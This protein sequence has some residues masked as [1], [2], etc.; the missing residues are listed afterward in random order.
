MGKIQLVEIH[1]FPVKGFSGQRLDA[2]QLE[3]GHGIAHDRRF[4]ITNGSAT[5][6]EWMPA[7]SFFINAVNDGMQKFDLQFPNEENVITLAGAGGMEIRIVPDDPKSLVEANRQIAEF[8]APVGLDDDRDPP[9]IVERAE[10]AGSGNSGFW[11]FTDT[12]ISVLNLNSLKSIEQRTG[13]EIDPRRFRANLVISGLPAWEEFGLLGTVLKVGDAELEVMRPA[14]RCPATSIDP[15]TGERDLTLPAD[16]QEHFG[17]AF[18]AMYARVVKGGSIKTGDAVSLEGASSM[19]LDE[20]FNERA[21]DY[22]LWPRIATIAEYQTGEQETKLSLES[23]SPWPL[24]DAKPGQRIRF[25]LDGPGWTFEEV[26]ATSPNRYQFK[27][28]DSK[29]DDPLTEMLRRGL[30]LGQKLIVSGPFGK[31]DDS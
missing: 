10:N 14:M 30:N 31:G 11:D 1:R 4:A 24:P 2:T 13:V 22:A 9:R 12:P 17:H 20:A 23:A 8:M 5:N 29:V 27:I 16:L 15:D 19:N 26:A 21:P 3:P 7:R 18:C 6:G 28:E 25:H